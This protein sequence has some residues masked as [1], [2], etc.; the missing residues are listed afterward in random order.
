MSVNNSFA[1]DQKRSRRL[2]KLY[3][4]IDFTVNTN[5]DMT[6]FRNTPDQPIVGN[7]EIGGK[8]F[9]VTIS[10]LNQIES[11]VSTAREA[12]NKHYMLNLNRR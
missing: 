6:A 9:P 10:E 11:T 5:L 2:G 7:F 12:V 4:T 8:S 1:F 3:N